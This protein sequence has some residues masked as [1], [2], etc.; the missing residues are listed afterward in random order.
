MA[1]ITSVPP[2]SG[3]PSSS[4]NNTAS[5]ASSSSTSQMSHNQIVAENLR[6]ST[7]NTILQQCRDAREI[8]VPAD[9]LLIPVP[10]PPTGT[11][12]QQWLSAYSQMSPNSQALGTTSLPSKAV[13]RPNTTNITKVLFDSLKEAPAG[14][15]LNST[16]NF[17]NIAHSQW[18]GA[19]E[20]EG[21]G[22]KPSTKASRWNRP[23]PTITMLFTNANTEQLHHEGHSLKRSKI[24]VNGSPYHLLDLLQFKNELDIDQ[25]S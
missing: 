16:Y 2:P 20:T 12:L 10:P 22:L 13:A 25:L 17:D 11:A 24:N 6:R 19:H 8:N 15:G 14:E 9:E 3:G 4:T 5:T 1:F 18:N 21:I 7:A 23:N